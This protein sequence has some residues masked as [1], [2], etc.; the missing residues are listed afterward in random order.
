[1][2]D[3]LCIT[4]FVGLDMT[5]V[6]SNYFLILTSVTSLFGIIGS[7][8]VASVG[9]SIVTENEEKNYRDMR[10]FNFMY[11]L[12]AGWAVICMLCL[13]QPWTSLTI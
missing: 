10:R 12:L 8:M 4:V 1:M 11:M 13:Y 2:I 6:Y 3:S 9:N 5:A 7:S